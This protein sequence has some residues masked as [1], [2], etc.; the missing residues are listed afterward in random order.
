[1]TNNIDPMAYKAN[2]LSDMS[3]QPDGI[4]YEKAIDD[5]GN[6]YYIIYDNFVVIRKTLDEVYSYCMDKGSIWVDVKE[7]PDDN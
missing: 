3:K 6:D 4:L 2:I 1:M 7:V 5:N